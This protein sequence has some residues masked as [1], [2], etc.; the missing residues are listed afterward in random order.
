MNFTKN[1][2]FVAK[3]F[4]G[5]KLLWIQKGFTLV[6]LIIVLTI[7]A[8]LATIA[9]LSFSSYTKNSRDSHR[10]MSG[11]N[12]ET[13]LSLFLAKTGKLPLPQDYITLTFDDEIIAYQW[14]FWEENARLIGFSTLPLDP[15][16]HQK[17]TYWVNVHQNKYQWTLF[18][19]HPLAY[20]HHSLFSN[21]LANNPDYSKRYIKTFGD[22]IG[23]L[24]WNSGSYFNTPLQIFRNEESF[25]GLE[26]KDYSWLVW[27]ENF[28]LW[29]LQ[30]VISDD[31]I[32][33]GT[34]EVVSEIHALLM[35]TQQILVKTQCPA[36]WIEMPE[37]FAAW[38]RAGTCDGWAWSCKV[39]QWKLWNHLPIWT[40][41]A[42]LS[43][44]NGWEEIWIVSWAWR[45]TNAVICQIG[46]NNAFLPW[47]QLTMTSCP[48]WWEEINIITA[49][50]RPATCNGMRCKVC[51]KK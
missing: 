5:G 45:A 39:C 17:I 31:E 6:E 25:T 44:Q 40:S 51:E 49:W 12:I 3:N 50:W 19:E 14:Y 46:N 10:L 32:L 48:A 30:V 8:I 28:E 9:F 35:T 22:K 42:A 4:W 41:I 43:C 38:W 27:Q 13:G 34:G 24:L 2:G 37:A 23:I 26:L 21:T 16:D 33:V 15:Y 11:K 36:W 18:L 1:N 20:S 47:T 7:L 29:E